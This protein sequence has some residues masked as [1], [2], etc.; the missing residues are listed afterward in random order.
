MRMDTGSVHGATR[1]TRVFAA[2]NAN[3]RDPRIAAQH[4]A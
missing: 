4:E 3:A 2:L 1:S